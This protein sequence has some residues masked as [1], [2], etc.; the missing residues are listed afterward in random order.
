KILAKT[1]DADLF[2]SLQFLRIASDYEITKTKIKN[3]EETIHSNLEKRKH[4]FEATIKNLNEINKLNEGSL[5]GNVEII[6]DLYKSLSSFIRLETLEDFRGI[7]EFELT[8]LTASNLKALENLSNK[9]TVGRMTKTLNKQSKVKSP[10]TVE[11]QGEVQKLIN[12][13]STNINAPMKHINFP[14]HYW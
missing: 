8:Q 5:I 10:A 6:S 12:T 11:Q 1:Q 9:N 13:F 7:S 2:N 14:G 3:R 4:L